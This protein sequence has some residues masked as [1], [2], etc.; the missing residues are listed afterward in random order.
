M[1]RAGILCIFVFSILLAFSHGHA[2]STNMASSNRCSIA[3]HRPAR[4]CTREKNFD[5]W[6]AQAL[7]EQAEI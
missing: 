3:R 4:G 2:E 6:R 1:N 7:I 5:A